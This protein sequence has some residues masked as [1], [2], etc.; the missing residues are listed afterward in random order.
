MGFLGARIWKNSF[1]KN[2]G[3]LFGSEKRLQPCVMVSETGQVSLERLAL[4]TGYCGSEADNVAWAV[5]QK[6]KLPMEG[7]DEWVLPISERSYIPLDPLGR[8]TTKDKLNL[9]SL[10]DIAEIKYLQAFTKVAEENKKS[11]NHRLLQTMI[12][13]ILLVTIIVVIVVLIKK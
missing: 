7:F 5:I 2:L 1:F 4:A 10:K 6:L 3:F 12:Y 9:L 8:L 11:A 13:G